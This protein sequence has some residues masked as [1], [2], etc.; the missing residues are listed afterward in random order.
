MTNIQG[1]PLPQ[2]R[3]RARQYAPMPQSL[4]DAYA[5]LGIDATEAE[6]RFR[7][8]VGDLKVRPVSMQP[9]RRT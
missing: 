3:F 9:K 5:Q 6:A 7:W 1:Q 8:L 4:L 2:E